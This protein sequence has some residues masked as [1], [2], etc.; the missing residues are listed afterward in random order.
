MNLYSKKTILVVVGATG[1]IISRMLF[2]FFDDPEGPNLLVVVALAMGLFLLSYAVYQL[3][4]LGVK[5]YMRLFAA[6]CI[7][8]LAVVGLY[9]SLR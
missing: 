9:F 4:P 2:F 8:I 6:I 5:A 3:S 7:Q 1:L